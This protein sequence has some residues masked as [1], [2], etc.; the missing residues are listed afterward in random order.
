MARDAVLL[1]DTNTLGMYRTDYASEATFETS[2]HRF[3]WRGLCADDAPPG[4]LVR[5]EIDAHTRGGLDLRVAQ[6][7]RHYPVRVVCECLR[8]AGL[9]TVAVLGQTSGAVLHR[10]HDE[11]AHRKTMFVAKRR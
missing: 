7:S 3:T 4:S 2:G 9:E 6:I 5:L 8:A 10:D 1:F 11:L